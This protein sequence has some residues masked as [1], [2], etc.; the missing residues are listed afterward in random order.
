[1]SVSLSE[2][3]LKTGF[4][5]SLTALAVA[6]ILF[7]GM[8]NAGLLPGG[9]IA[10]IKLAW[11]ATA[12]LFWYL[13]PALLLLDRRMPAPARIACSVLLVNMILRALVELILMY[14]TATWHP[15]MG[16]GHDVFSVCLMLLVLRPCYGSSDRSYCEYLFVATAMFVPEAVFAWYMLAKAKVAG[17]TIYFV[18]D[19]PA[20]HA[21]MMTTAFCILLLCIFLIRFS[22]QWLRLH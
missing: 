15:W 22:R 11:L 5:A 10:P 19:E 7:Y 17:T 3:Q 6:A 13:I 16:I 1:M 18:P 4:F 12:V 21:I 14:G 2:S 20:H 9:S 8:Q